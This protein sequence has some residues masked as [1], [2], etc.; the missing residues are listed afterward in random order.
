MSLAAANAI[1]GPCGE[2]QVLVDNSRMLLHD[3]RYTTVGS[4]D[5]SI[6]NGPNE[7]PS[8]QQLDK[9]VDE[10]DEES[11]QASDP[12]SWTLGVDGET[13]ANEDEHV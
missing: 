9:E 7:K 10:A 5:N 3:H 13:D 6:V 11:F 12:P 8:K 1:I 4:V 2:L